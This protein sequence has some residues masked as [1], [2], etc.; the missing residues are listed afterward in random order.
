MKATS[1]IQ[2]ARV[3]RRE[4]AVAFIGLV[5]P[6]MSSDPD[7]SRHFEDTLGDTSDIVL[8]GNGGR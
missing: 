2:V 3:R 5:R 1:F 6:R 8:M 4:I 7:T